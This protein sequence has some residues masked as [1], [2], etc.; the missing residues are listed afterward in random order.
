MSVNE[1]L[2][3]RKLRKSSASDVEEVDSHDVTDFASA[4]LA[5]RLNQAPLSKYVLSTFV[6]PTSNVLEGFFR[7]AGYAYLELRQNLLPMKLEQQLLLK[8]NM[9]HWDL[10]TVH[11]LVNLSEIFDL[12]M[13]AFVT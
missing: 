2:L 9:K 8:F 3:C 7:S 10:S 6:L 13:L 5:K 4:V 11:D 12:E 1:Q